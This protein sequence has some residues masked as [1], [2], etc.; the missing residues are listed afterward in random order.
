MSAHACTGL[1]MCADGLLSPMDLEL[2]LKVNSNPRVITPFRESPS[3][4]PLLRFTDTGSIARW[5]VNRRMSSASELPEL[6]I[7]RVEDSNSSS[8]EIRYQRVNGTSTDFA[9]GDL[10]FQMNI[11]LINQEISFRE[12]DILA[13]RSSDRI[14]L[15]D[16]LLN[17]DDYGSSG[18]EPGDEKLEID[19]T[20]EQGEIE[21]SLLIGMSEAITLRICEVCS[22]FV[23]N[24][25]VLII[26][27]LG[28]VI[29]VASAL[30][31]R[32]HCHVH[33]IPIT[34]PPT[35]THLEGECIN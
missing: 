31:Q 24:F 33:G 30:K 9:D 4:S 35:F 1:S 21:I 19:P 16:L 25:N 15:G 6:Q 3:I 7:W 11:T 28:A 34:C 23:I 32:L 26:S 12:G 20:Y 13:V 22:V 29:S 2:F 27:N 18:Y 10:N 8:G 14:V 5:A 17:P